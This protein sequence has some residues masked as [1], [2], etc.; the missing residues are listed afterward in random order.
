MM[1]RWFLSYH[2]PDRALAERLK[3]AI[4]RKDKGAVVFFAP[5]SLRP[6]GRWARALAEAIDEA[7]AFVLLVTD[8]GIGR[9]QEIEYHA[10]FEAKDARTLRDLFEIV[11]E[12]PDLDVRIDGKRLPYAH[13]LWLPL[14]WMF[15]GG[16]A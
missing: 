7:S 13:E 9:W 6:G 10:A 12:R 3:A 8:R 16:E 15:V 1:G 5:E 11:K 14:V 4:E 2:S